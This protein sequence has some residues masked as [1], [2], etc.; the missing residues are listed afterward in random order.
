VFYLLYTICFAWLVYG[1]LEVR[2]V[3]KTVGQRHRILDYLGISGVEMSDTDKAIVSRYIKR[4][5]LSFILMAA[6]C[7]IISIVFRVLL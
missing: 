7:I 5:F 1:G 3:N 6:S 4:M 2:R